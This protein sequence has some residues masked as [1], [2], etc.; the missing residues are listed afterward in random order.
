VDLLRQLLAKQ[1]QQSEQ[2][3]EL[4]VAVTN[5]QARLAKPPKDPFPITNA[6]LGV[7]FA[8]AIQ[9]LILIYWFGDAKLIPQMK[10]RRQI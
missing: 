2:I 10:P 7:I 3:E 6:L 1:I 8:V 5:I 9:V 4:K